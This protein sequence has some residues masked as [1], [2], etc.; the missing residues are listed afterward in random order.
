MKNDKKNGAKTQMATRRPRKPYQTGRRHPLGMPTSM[1]SKVTK[2]ATVPTKAQM[3]Q[4]LGQNT[5]SSVKAVSKQAPVLTRM[6]EA[7]KREASGQD[8]TP[9][10]KSRE[11][12]L[13]AVLAEA[14]FKQASV[15][16]GKSA[17]KS[18]DAKSAHVPA[19]ASTKRASDLHSA[20]RIKSK[21]AKK[22]AA[23][24]EA[25]TQQASGQDVETSH[26]RKKHKNAAVKDGKGWIMHA[27]AA[28][29]TKKPAPI[30]RIMQARAALAAEKPAPDRWASKPKRQAPDGYTSTSVKNVATHKTAAPSAKT[31]QVPGQ[32]GVASAKS[33]VNSG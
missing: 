29:A 2:T 9:A 33:G 6:A 3:M 26:K 22:A 15:Q 14:N 8:A 7:R 11:T 13:A 21:V 5:P 17:L 31:K 23:P 20:I 32:D 25:R 1:K 4:V 30:T 27:R 24:N 10:V 12:K 18:Q 28:M 16:A 19:R